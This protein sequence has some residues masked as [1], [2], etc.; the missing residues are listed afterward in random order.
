MSHYE[1]IITVSD[2][3]E[4]FSHIDSYDFLLAIKNKYYINKKKTKII[5]QGDEV[6]FHALAPKF[7]TDPDGY[8]PGHELE[9]AIDRLG[10]L[11]DIF[12]E[13]D[14]C[15]SN[16]TMRPLRKAFQAGIPRAFL[17]SIGEFLS[18]PKGYLWRQKWEYNGIVFEHGEGVSGIN[19]ALN[20]A[21]KNRKS[22]SIGH[23]HCYGG[24]V[25]SSSDHDTIWGM[26]TGCLI[27]VDAYVFAYATTCR[28][29]PTLGTGVILDN[30]PFFIPMV[31]DKAGRWIG[32]LP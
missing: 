8:G 1:S 6:D 24:V 15:I 32:K 11:Y 12:P 30:V 9:A 14:V 31:L 16:H 3:Q 27:D 28:N 10:F 17:R 26:N 5:G 21:I 19:A 29:K 22:T 25:Y 4:P 20:A 7:P 2:L 23:Q 18:A 13:M